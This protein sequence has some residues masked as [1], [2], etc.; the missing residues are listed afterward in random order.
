MFDRLITNTL[1]AS[2]FPQNGYL[3]VTEATSVVEPDL[4]IDLITIDDYSINFT[5]SITNQNGFV[6]LGFDITS[7]S[8]PTHA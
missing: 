1:N 6:Y 5:I 2:V 3:T 4:G 8:L 7:N